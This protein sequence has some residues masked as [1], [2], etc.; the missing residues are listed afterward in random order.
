[1]VEPAIQADE[2]S[3]RDK[4]EDRLDRA[5]RT[6][7]RRRFFNDMPD[8]G[9]FALIAVMGFTGILYFKVRGSDADYV[10]GGAVALMIAY[11]FIA[12]Q[13]RR[14]RLRPDRLGDNFYYLGF[15]YT[16]AS[17]SAALLQMRRGAPI[18][19]LL[20]SFGI[21]LFTTIIGVAGR[22]L[23][24]QMR[25][26]IDEVEDEVRKDLLNASADLRAQLNITLAEFETFQTGI[27][28]ATR[29]AAEQ[30]AATAQ[31]D[32][33]ASADVR[34]QLNLTLAELETFKA[35]VQRT[36]EKAAEQSAADAQDTI[37]NIGRVANA[38]AENIDRAFSREADK[39][40]SFEQAAVRIEKGLKDL[41]VEISDRVHDLADGIDKMVTQL[42]AAVDFVRRTRARFR[43]WPFGRKK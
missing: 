7:P 34:E 41:T 12:F 22:V 8:K 21:A 39:L 20:G 19:D 10:A 9:L 6:L 17:L 13:F 18:D 1:M 14:V 42:A 11:G 27:Q 15:I 32:L 4:N 29:K 3:S 23:F 40:H 26:D 2:P 24:V 36:A 37:S 30:S 16:L 43:L 28:Q 38:A 5:Q 25:G 33:N 31:K 35:G